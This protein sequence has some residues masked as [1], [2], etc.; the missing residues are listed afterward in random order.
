MGFW[1]PSSWGKSFTG[2][3][4]WWLTLSDDLLKLNANSRS[5]EA[6]I[7]RSSPIEINEGIFWTDLT[8]RVKG[9]DSIRVDG[10]PN[11][12]GRAIR[13]AIAAVVEEK[14]V[15]A[16]RLELETRLKSRRERF[17][18]AIEPILSWHYEILRDVARHRQER[19]W[20]TSESLRRYMDSKPVPLVT[21]SELIQMLAEADIQAFLG[22]K[23]KV[24][25]TATKLWSANLKGAVARRN[26]EHVK[27]ELV[28]CK[29][30]FD[31]IEKMPLTEEQARAVICFDN[32]VQ[33][34]ASAGSGKTST[35]VAKAAYA[36]DRGLI[37]PERIC[38]L[39]F[40]DSASKELQKRI[41][42]GLKRIGREDV[43]V[44]AM[45][46]HKFGLDVIGKATGRKPR[47]ASWVEQERDA[48]KLEDLIDGLK[49]RSKT[50]RTQWDLFRVVFS[51]DIPK[52]GVETDHEDYDKISGKTGFSTLKGDVVKSEQERTLA[53]WLFYNGIPYIYER[54]YEHPT[55]T[56]DHSQYHPDFYYPTMALYHEHQALD[57]EG[58]PP[59]KFPR[60]M[61]KVI[62]ARE[63]H[64]H[65]QT[66]CIETTSAQM[67]DGSAFDHLEA[68]FKKRGVTL[69]PD[70]NRPVAGR[71]PL[72]HGDL[73]RLFRSFITHAKS[74]CLSVAELRKRI[75]AEDFDAFT[76][77]HKLFLALYG[78]IRNAW[79]EAL[80][81]AD[82]IDFEDM[83]NMAGEHLEAG[84][85][86]SPY[87]L[88]MVDEFQDAS[89]AR[90]RMSQALVKQPGR[91]LFV[92]GDDW[93]S[94]N[95]FAGADIS[96]M[97][98]F[99][100]WCGDAQVLKLERTFRCPQA[101]CDASSAFVMKN[102]KQIPKKVRSE[103]LQIGPVL[104]AFQVLDRTRIRG[105]VRLHLQSIYEQLRDGSHPLGKNGKVSVYVLGRYNADEHYVPPSWKSDFGDKMAVE[106][107]TIHK[108]KG[109]EADYIVL[110][111][112]AKH[113][114]PSRKEDDPVLRLAMPAEDPYPKSEERRLFYVALTR[115]RRS[116]AM[117][118]VQGRESPFLIE[119]MKGGWVEVL[120]ADGEPSTAI[121]CPRCR[122]GVMVQK[123]G[124]NGPFMSCTNFPPCKKTMN[125]P[126]MPTSGQRTV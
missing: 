81:D 23:L 101:L 62:W 28:A 73:V 115:A 4:N 5:Y 13:Q 40:N 49:D 83:L 17:I 37:A 104:Q 113:G 56:A 57:G 106:F 26:E 44:A 27:A 58:K 95:R 80:T 86:N 96:V 114:F 122:N 124:R 78:P 42:L 68:E 94:I 24:A 60:Y 89:W 43:K 29:N 9:Q 53:D 39:A 69:D 75:K 3:G 84:N 93:Q 38:M 98:G 110:P 64:A 117:F 61:E 97:T 51:R 85:W 87:E 74:N 66:D 21:T 100:D 88:I 18:A 48:E 119:L 70:P 90:A 32:R 46:F 103:T 45:T 1:S 111:H 116:V 11:A 33:V 34:I 54:P 41:E 35:M 50:F 99:R 59:D 102:E 10:I 52:F 12:H 123:S 105:A 125:I 15:A 65:F 107:H 36:V 121:V 82:A 6:R 55:A 91:F 126:H 7:T 109:S 8:L 31:S 19:R 92:V 79:D 118:T 72:K 76:Y 108:S 2:S 112:L 71:E 25:Q 14:R 20:I 67:W 16:A 47:I 22:D 77:R 120:D 63:Q 30:L